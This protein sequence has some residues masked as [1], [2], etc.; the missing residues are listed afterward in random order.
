MDRVPRTA[1]R[2]YP[3]LRIDG[4][5]PLFKRLKLSSV[6][7]PCGKDW[8]LIHFE[9]EALTLQFPTEDQPRRL[10]CCVIKGDDPVPGVASQEEMEQ[11]F[12][13]NPENMQE[14][15][16]ED[17]HDQGADDDDNDDQCIE[18]DALGCDEGFE[19][20][21]NDSGEDSQAGEPDQNELELG[22]EDLISA[23]HADLLDIWAVEITAEDVGVEAAASKLTSNED[24]ST[25]HAGLY[26]TE[27]KEKLL[28][29]YVIGVKLQHRGSLDESKLACGFQAWY[30]TTSKWFSYGSTLKAKYDSKDTAHKAALDWVWE[31]HADVVGHEAASTT[32]AKHLSK[33]GAAEDAV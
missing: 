21:E 8:R 28:L 20:Q 15:E 26:T 7:L 6:L 31:R 24:E 3:C 32:R 12:G 16:T 22:L 18:K 25:K 14:K 9:A 30:G 23:E 27:Q 10:R 4:T 13:Q 2:N 29:P 33:Y 17:E 1:V 11:L 19:A 5:N